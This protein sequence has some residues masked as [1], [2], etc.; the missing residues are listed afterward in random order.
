MKKERI[1]FVNKTV[2]NV[3]N[4]HQLSYVSFIGRACDPTIKSV[5]NTASSWENSIAKKGGV[6][7]QTMDYLLHCSLQL[8]VAICVVVDCVVRVNICFYA[9]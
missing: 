9:G 1:F 3:K 8:F 5:A 7:L 4:Y 6:S 2:E